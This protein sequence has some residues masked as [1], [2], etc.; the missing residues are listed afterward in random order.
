[1][2]ADHLT[3]SNN[4]PKLDGWVPK[5]IAF[6]PAAYTD[7]GGVATVAAAERV[8]WLAESA[9]DARSGETRD[10]AADE[11]I[12]EAPGEDKRLAA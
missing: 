8:C 9:A 7:R 6:P 4:R 3:G 10:D 1:V 11:A 2:I 5:W 12:R